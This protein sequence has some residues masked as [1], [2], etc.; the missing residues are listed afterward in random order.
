MTRGRLSLGHVVALVAALALM[1]VMAMDWYTTKLGEERREAERN[2]EQLERVEP[3]LDEDASRLA[4]EEERN[5]WQEDGVIDRILLLVL[6]AAVAAA[7]FAAIV[8]AAGRRFTPPRTPSVAVAALALAAEVLVAYRI[9][10]EPETDS[11]TELTIGPPLA[12]LCLAAMSFG[13]FR[14][15]RAEEEGPTTDEPAGVEARDA[16]AATP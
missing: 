2:A 16:E 1:L 7:V 9:V 3:T 6:L 12:I 5:A 10:Q 15:M 13:A 4:E 8:Y 14:A 11:I